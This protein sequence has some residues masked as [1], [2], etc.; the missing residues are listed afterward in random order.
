MATNILVFSIHQQC[1]QYILDS[2]CLHHEVHIYIE[3][4]SVWPL[5][6]IGT[7]P[8]LSPA[9]VSLPPNQEGGHTRL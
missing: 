1:V 9:S 8:L 7:P 3:Y 6:G 2:L 4:H 5:V